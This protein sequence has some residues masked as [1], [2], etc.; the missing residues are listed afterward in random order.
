M[1]DIVIIG[2]HSVDGVVGV[3]GKLP[4]RL[5]TDLSMFKELTDGEIV[6]MGRKTYESIGK[7]LSNRINIVVSSKADKRKKVRFKKGE[8][9]FVTMEFAKSIA[10]QSDTDVYVIGGASVWK[11]FL[12]IASGAVITVVDCEV[13]GDTYFPKNEFVQSRFKLIDK[14]DD[15]KRKGDEYPFSI[16]IYEKEAK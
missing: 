4:W 3:D 13:K 2:A 15:V 9:S 6:I 12:Q 8:V 14:L 5:P 7:P 11:E 1:A 16:K 10:K